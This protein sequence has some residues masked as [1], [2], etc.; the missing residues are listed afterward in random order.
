MK[1]LKQKEKST[2]SQVDSFTKEEEKAAAWFVIFFNV[3][4]EVLSANFHIITILSMMTYSI[5]FHSWLGFVFLLA[6]NL[7]WVI[8]KTH[9][10][11]INIS[12][13][14]VIYAI[15]IIII[16]YLFDFDL[17]EEELQSIVNNELY[18]NASKIGLRT[19][20]TIPIMHLMLKIILMLPCWVTMRQKYKAGE[21][22]HTVSFKSTLETSLDI[23]ERNKWTTPM[24]RKLLVYAWIWSINLIIFFMA[25]K[26]EK[27]TMIRIINMT[28][29][30]AFVAIFQVSFRI[31]KKVMHT[32]FF[33]LIVYSKLLLT[34]VYVYQFNNFVWPY[35]EIIGLFKL[36]VTTLFLKLI[37]LSILSVMSGIYLNYLHKIFLE[38]N[39][40][41]NVKFN[42]ENSTDLNES[43]KLLSKIMSNA[44]KFFEKLSIL[45]EIHLYK[46]IFV[47]TFLNATAKVGFYFS[48]NFK[49]LSKKNS[50]S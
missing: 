13:A 44:T 17:T 15:L 16:N 38:C 48:F 50:F 41:V 18:V 32:Y 8:P 14:I 30:L 49:L 46:I 31:W 9:M 21:D 4:K 29:V 12:P 37:V 19:S 3:S 39:E 35:D 27:M 40:D 1:L 7:L 26:G 6:A 43:Y 45:I 34:I 23:N 11:M 36:Q 10:S 24:V 47:I 28:F 20:S 25:I 42:N 5:I 33:V 2:Y 22:G